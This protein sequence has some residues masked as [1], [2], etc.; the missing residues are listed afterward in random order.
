MRASM[1]LPC[2]LSAA[3]HSMHGRQLRCA[4]TR[5]RRLR[6]AFQCTYVGCG[7]HFN[8]H[9][10]VAARI[11]MRIRR[12]RRAF[13]CAYVGC[14]THFNVHTSVAARFSMHIHQ[15]RHA[16]QCTHIRCSTHFNAQ[17]SVAAH[18]SRMMSFYGAGLKP[19]K[20]YTSDHAFPRRALPTACSSACQARANLRRPAPRAAARAMML[21]EPSPHAAG[22]AIVQMP[23]TC[24][25]VLTTGLSYYII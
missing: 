7:A 19:C 25:C 21:A 3:R 8:A 4:L 17:T 13:Q 16:F 22:R 1:H 24:R 11:K 2:A 5:K 23:K 15:L 18:V 9:T 6:R 12:L 14:G 10:S 20:A